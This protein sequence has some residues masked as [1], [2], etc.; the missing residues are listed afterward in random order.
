MN[1][2][3]Y[4]FLVV[5]F[6]GTSKIFKL[7]IGSISLCLTYIA[8]SWFY[9]WNTLSISLFFTIYFFPMMMEGTLLGLLSFLFLFI[10]IMLGCCLALEEKDEKYEPKFIKKLVIKLNNFSDDISSYGEKRSDY[11]ERRKERRRKKQEKKLE[12]QKKEKL[13]KEKIKSRF[14]ILDI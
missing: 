11:K 1:N 14:E 5:I 4:H 13:E 12:Q 3:I 6:A 7:I 2:N 9:N 10:S 8:R